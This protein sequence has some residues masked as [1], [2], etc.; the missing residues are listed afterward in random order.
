MSKGWKGER[1]ESWGGVRGRHLSNGSTVV[2][3]SPAEQRAEEGALVIPAH[4]FHFLEKQY[5]NREFGH[6]SPVHPNTQQPRELV[7]A[8]LSS[9]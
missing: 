9:S 8:M 5:R 3:L 2:T 1:V 7:P 6:T 4:E